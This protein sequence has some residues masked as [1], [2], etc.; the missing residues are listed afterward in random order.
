[1]PARHPLTLT[2]LA[3]LA[4]PVAP[5]A[6][7]DTN[8]YGETITILDDAAGYSDAPLEFS[9]DIT[10]A[11]PLPA[12]TD[13]DGDL[14]ARIRAGYAL[15][16][17]N[18]PYTRKHES[19]YAS[20]PDYVRRMMDRSRKYLYH[21]V[22]EVEKRG[23]PSEIAL[24]PMVESA[25]N[26]QAYSRSHAAGIWQ[27]IPSTGRNFGLKQNWWVDKRRDVLAAT[28]AALNYLHK[29]HVMFGS[30]ELALAAYNAG[31]GTV[32][33]AIERNRKQGLPTDY[34]NLDLPAETREYVP[35]LQAVKNIVTHP[36]RYGLDIRP[37]ANAPYFTTVRAPDQIDA[38]LAARL[39]GISLEEFL[40]LNPKYNRPVL[41]STSQGSHLI[42][43]P[44]GAER[45]FAE[46]LANYDQ[47]LVSWQ[48][49]QARR[50]ERLD[51]IARKFGMSVS[52]LREVNDLPAK[53][54]L[55]A[56]RQLLVQRG[57]ES[58]H[59]ALTVSA[60]P[61]APVPQDSGE[62]QRHVVASGDTLSSVARRYG[63]TTRALIAANQ[64]KSHRLQPG[65]VLRL[66][67]AAPARLAR[68]N[69]P[70]KLHYVV[71]KGDTLSA[72][73]RK[74]DV[75]VNDLRRW[76]NLRGSQITP[77]DRLTILS[78]DAA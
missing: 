57:G 7:A 62:A 49:Y 66:E 44:L 59:A 20:R 16:E 12:E 25:F 64:L 15:P 8:A 31:E 78:A 43:L 21:I 18:S 6:H 48:T 24:L 53:A 71:R 32:M 76:N 40:A 41:T 47:P 52:Q 11:E 3:F 22:E 10:D 45:T 4:L 42:L 5:G 17:L 13:D 77:G 51:G 65:Q 9:Y 1:M 55:D 30:W 14:L 28:D 68:A 36:E 38:N 39:A 37:I 19:W 74:F 75:A 23:M 34:Q 61:P 63:T 60:A 70:A 54:S 29:L 67:H 69:P 73:A 27:F 58:A 2:L 46:N 35:K 56:P 50:G 72:I 26:P 33:R